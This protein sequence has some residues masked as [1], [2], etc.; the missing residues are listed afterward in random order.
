MA[1]LR[2]PELPAGYDFDYIN[3]DVIEHRLQVRRWPFRA[4]R[5][6]VLPAAGAAPADDDAA[7][8]VA[9]DPRPGGGG[10]GGLRPAAH[11]FAQ[12]ARLPGLRRRG[13]ASLPPSCGARAG[14]CKAPRWRPPWPSSHTPP[15]VVCSGNILFTHRRDGASD[16]YFLTNQ[17]ESPRDETIT[18]RVDGRA[19]EF[20]WPETGRTERP[21]VYDLGRGTV[22]MPIH[23]GPATSLFVVF[24]EP[25][26]KDRVVGPEVQHA[27]AGRSWLARARR[28]AG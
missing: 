19:P 20:W 18:F 16:V 7:G 24:R 27:A 26:S 13:E 22:R 8:A 3:A 2:K 14:S 6:H 9:E 28:D 1:G 12:P 10:R 11:A 25:A 5:R 4:A 21:A 17:T 23:F 15:D